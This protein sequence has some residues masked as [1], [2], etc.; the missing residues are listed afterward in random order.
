MSDHKLPQNRGASP[1]RRRQHLPTPVD[2]QGA[3]TLPADYSLPPMRVSATPIPRMECPAHLYIEG[4]ESASGARSQMYLLSNVARMFGA[5]DYLHLA[6]QDLTPKVIVAVLAKLRDQGYKQSSRNAYLAAMRGTAR[7]AWRDGL[8]SAD[9]YERLKDIKNKKSA[10]QVQA[11]Q[12]VTLDVQ[13]EL[14]RSAVNNGKHTSRRDALIISILAFTGIRREEITNIHYPSD[15]IY[16]AEDDTWQI[17]IHGKGNKDRRCQ[18]PSAIMNSL[19]EY[20]EDE[21]GTAEGALFSRY[22]RS[23]PAPMPALN[24]LDTSMINSIINDSLKRSKELSSI[25]ITPHDLRRSFATTMNAQGLGLRELQ[26]LLGHSNSSTTERY[27]RDDH[28]EYLKKAAKV[29]DDLLK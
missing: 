9:T 15:F 19:L 21:R 2:Q 11:G 17:V 8:L 27:I 25:R 10:D 28:S 13:K 12:A 18:P 6:W 22:R 7:Q 3:S 20:I 24:P 1:G 26:I 23:R 4:L 14:I 5:K 29:S 16:F